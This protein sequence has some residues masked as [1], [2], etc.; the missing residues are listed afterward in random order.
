MWGASRALALRFQDLW[1][2]LAGGIGGEERHVHRH[3]RARVSA[4]RNNR[5][6][7]IGDM[8]HAGN[9]GDEA[10]TL[11]GPCWRNGISIARLPLVMFSNCRIGSPDRA[12]QRN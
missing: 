10:G 2:E 12:A 4:Y 5:R 7:A 8:L 9:C 1:V 11:G 3:Y 6:T